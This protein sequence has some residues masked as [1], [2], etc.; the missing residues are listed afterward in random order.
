M[1]V[2]TR[3]LFVLLGFKEDWAA[4][5][6][7]LPGYTYDFGTF[8]LSASEV[9]DRYGS[10]VFFL[11]GVCR[12]ERT[13]A[14]ITYQYPLKVASVDQGLALLAYAL[15]RYPPSRPIEWLDR[16][17]LLE[18]LLPWV[19]RQELLDARPH[20]SVPRDW[21][22]LVVRE[23]RELA[24]HGADDDRAEFGFDGAVLRIKIRGK[25]IATTATGSAWDQTYTVPLNALE[26]LPK[27]LMSDPVWIGVW[28][29]RLEIG[30]LSIQLSRQGTLL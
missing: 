29:E 5:T 10:P 14:Q 7:R 28:Q 22:R 1:A 26:A 16:G 2:S 19:Q 4:L 23:V 25:T 13:L 9:M 27:R 11:S 8:V 15:R 30:S 17:A 3:K 6:N 21:F 18:E 12:T 24:T 20:C